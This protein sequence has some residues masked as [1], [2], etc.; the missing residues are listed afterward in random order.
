VVT[1]QQRR[2]FAT[3]YNKRYVEATLALAGKYN[4]LQRPVTLEEFVA[5]T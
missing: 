3:S 2:L 1:A 4:L 5:T